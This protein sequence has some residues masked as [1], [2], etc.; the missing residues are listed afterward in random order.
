[1]DTPSKE[2]RLKLLNQELEIWIN[3]RYL[4]QTRHGV[5][6]DIGADLAKLNEI[7]RELV[8]CEMAIDSLNKRLRIVEG[9]DNDRVEFSV[10]PHENTSPN[11][12]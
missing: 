6:K 1:M 11:Q 9:E 3:T 4:Y 10:A 2:V 5:N 7:E 12:H 8:K